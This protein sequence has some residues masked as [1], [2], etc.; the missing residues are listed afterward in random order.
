M[1]PLSALYFS[2]VFTALFFSSFSKFIYNGTETNLVFIKAAKVSGST[3]AG[4][5]RR[6][7]DHYGLNGVHTSIWTRDKPGE[8]MVWAAES[9][10]ALIEDIEPQIASLKLPMFFHTI[11]RD[12]VARC[13]SEFMHFRV[14]RGKVAPTDANKINAIKG[15]KDN[16]LRY[17]QNHK[18]PLSADRI[19]NQ[20][21]YIYTADRFQESVVLLAY[22]L[23]INFCDIL[24]LDAKIPS[25]SSKVDDIGYKVVAHKRIEQESAK[26]QEILMANSTKALMPQ[27]Y[28]LLHMVND[29]MD[30]DIAAIGREKF[31]ATLTQLQHYLALPAAIVLTQINTTG[32][33][34]GR[35]MIVW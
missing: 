23:K 18:L 3:W 12:P 22:R 15:C 32:M 4:V 20:Y 13:M 14:T 8:P 19:F 1:T 26:V 9:S 33:T 16:M 17:L 27:S 31:D 30:K 11:I 7:A 29:R 35:A 6:I 28:K 21:N 5:I 2:L 25:S 34:V 24:Y 10:R